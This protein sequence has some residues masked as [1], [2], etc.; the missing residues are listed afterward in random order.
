MSA[1]AV[2][3]S[4]ET[5]L[6]MRSGHDPATRWLPKP[7]IL[8]PSPNERFDT[9]HPKPEPDAVTLH[10]RIRAGGPPERVVV[11]ATE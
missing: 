9:K 7:R 1:G 2:R 10:A 11:T 6:A 8:H 5:M 3:H 4:P